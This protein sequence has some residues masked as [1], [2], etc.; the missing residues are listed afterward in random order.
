MKEDYKWFAVRS[1][2]EHDKEQ[3]RRVIEQRILMYLVSDVDAAL[4]RADSDSLVYLDYNKGFLQVS[5]YEVFELGH[6]SMN[7]DGCEVWSFVSF[8]PP[9]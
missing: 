8:D 1:F 3:D 5:G 2:F 4:K 7:L 9:K 6:G